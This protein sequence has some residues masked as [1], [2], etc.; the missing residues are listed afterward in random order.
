MPRILKKKDLMTSEDWPNMLVTVDDWFHAANGRDYKV[1]YG[2]ACVCAAKDLLG[3]HPG[4]TN[5]TWYLL[6][7]H[8][9]N[10]AVIA[11]CRVH[12]ALMCPKPPNMEG[13]L[14]LSGG[15]ES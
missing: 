9:G 13:V 8:P 14:D 1:V 6:V 11:G 5:A 10:Q 7:G 12:Y 3:I 15:Q 4:G 2:P